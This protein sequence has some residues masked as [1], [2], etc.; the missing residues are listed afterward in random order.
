MAIDITELEKFKRSSQRT[1]AL[2]SIA[3][4]VVI[5]GLL[6]SFIGTW[7]STEQVE[8]KT[9]EVAQKQI[10]ISQKE[11]QLQELEQKKKLAEEAERHLTNGVALA[12]RRQL[13]EAIEEY[14][15]AIEL[16]PDSANAYQFLGYAYFARNRYYKKQNNQEK[17][18]KYSNDL[19]DSVK[20][21]EMAVQ[22]DPD[23]IWAHYNLSLAY[24]ATGEKDKAVATARKI[25]TLDESFRETIANDGQFKRE[26]K[27]LLAIS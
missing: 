24:W 19:N 16:N 26:F 10:E 25:L 23:Y 3:G 7:K 18:A 17:L 6:I 4:G 14:K 2:S 13:T 12:E 11:N 20:T 21:L 27:R 9:R 8:E 1:V 22:L 5:L 15:K